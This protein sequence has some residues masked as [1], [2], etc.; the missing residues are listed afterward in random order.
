MDT[1]RRGRV[2]GSTAAVAMA[3]LAAGAG[4]SLLQCV[5]HDVE[6]IKE[7]MESLSGAPGEDGAS[8]RVARRAGADVDEAGPVPRPRLQ[9]LHRPLPPA[10]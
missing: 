6:F 1:V 8:R 2:V 9:Q 4:S 3:E 10:W 7:E 5:G